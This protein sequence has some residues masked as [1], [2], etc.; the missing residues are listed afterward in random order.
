MIVSEVL[1]IRFRYG[2]GREEVPS[3]ESVIKCA[4][5]CVCVRVLVVHSCDLMRRER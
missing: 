5:V 2:S 3:S 1:K 4:C